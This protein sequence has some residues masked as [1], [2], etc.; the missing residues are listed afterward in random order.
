MWFWN[1]PFTVQC[2]TVMI[3]SCFIMSLFIAHIIYLVYFYLSLLVIYFR[4]FLFI[5]NNLNAILLYHILTA[6]LNLLLLIFLS[7]S[8][9]H[10]SSTSRKFY[11]TF[12]FSHDSS[13]IK[14]YISLDFSFKQQTHI[15]L[16]NP[17]VSIE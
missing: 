12:K 2:W 7:H 9:H 15:H 11:L 8:I 14:K 16:A 4:T 10:C 5:V 1:R 3:G 17:F 13:V 6:N